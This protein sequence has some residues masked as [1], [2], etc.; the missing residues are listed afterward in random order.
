MNSKPKPFSIVRIWRRGN[1][2]ARPD[3]T[4][5]KMACKRGVGSAPKYR[6]FHTLKD[7]MMTLEAWRRNGNLTLD[8]TIKFIDD[9]EEHPLN[10]EADWALAILRS[11]A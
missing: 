5:Y 11:L 10:T 9:E 2:P 3:R 7:A 6:G 8:A 4:K 1:S